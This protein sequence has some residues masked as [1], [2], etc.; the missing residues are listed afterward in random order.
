MALFKEVGLP[1]RPS[2]EKEEKA[3]HFYTTLNLE[4]GRHYVITWLSH[5][6]AMGR[7]P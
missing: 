5:L 4:M 7:S 6:W 1:V 2:E 3:G